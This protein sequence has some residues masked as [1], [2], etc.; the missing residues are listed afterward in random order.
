MNP[1][2]VLRG[3]PSA[4]VLVSLALLATLAGC[5]NRPAEL[6]G[7]TFSS[8]VDAGTRNLAAAVQEPPLPPIAE[9]EAPRLRLWTDGGFRQT[10]DE[11]GVS[12]DEDRIWDLVVPA[13]ET[14][15]FE[16][17]ARPLNGRGKVTGYRWALDLVDI[18]DETPRIDPGDLA[19][20]SVWS[21]AERS[22]TVGPFEDPTA[23]HYFYVEARD[24]VGFISLVTVRIQ[25]GA[26]AG[27]VEGLPLALR[28]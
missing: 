20:W 2:R 16:W 21:L 28:R 18:L 7:P 5:S 24:R 19:H 15:T 25:V 10:Q 8:S 27:T 26:E 6:V 13:G 22:A 9:W 3:G 23:V 11:G 12:L 1:P 17:S 14:V 4:A